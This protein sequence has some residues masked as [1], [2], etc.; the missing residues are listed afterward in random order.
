MDIDQ[1]RN[2]ELPNS[3][4]FEPSPPFDATQ[5]RISLLE[6]IVRGEQV[7]SDGRVVPHERARERMRR[8]LAHP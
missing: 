6:G 5:Y 7:I 2:R 1:D 8:W 3:G 4:S